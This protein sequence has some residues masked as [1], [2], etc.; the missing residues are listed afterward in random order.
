MKSEIQTGKSKPTEA[1]IDE[2]VI[3]QADDHSA[4]EKPIY[5]KRNKPLNIPLPHKLAT[6]V[7]FFARL[8]RETSSEAW[9]QRIVQERLNFEEAAFTQLKRS[10]AFNQK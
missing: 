2:L 1:A 4:W 6:R 7:A 9:L 10:L 8:H 3:S 5:V